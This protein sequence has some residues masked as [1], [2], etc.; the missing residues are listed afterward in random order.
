MLTFTAHTYTLT[1]LQQQVLNQRPETGHGAS[2]SLKKLINKETVGGRILPNSEVNLVLISGTSRVKSPI[3]NPF[4]HSA[5]P[6]SWFGGEKTSAKHGAHLS[7]G[8]RKG[9][10]GMPAE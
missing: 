4:G 9:S 3:P 7:I 10:G 5:L 8:P 1:S 2:E 6:F